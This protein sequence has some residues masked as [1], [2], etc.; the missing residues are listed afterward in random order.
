M[1]SGEAGAAMCCS[2]HA[3]AR[4]MSLLAM[5]DL[6]VEVDGWLPVYPMCEEKKVL[7]VSRQNE[8]QFEHFVQFLF[9]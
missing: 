7:G 3:G 2:L 4:A 5:G 8:G 9:F 1:A 6:L